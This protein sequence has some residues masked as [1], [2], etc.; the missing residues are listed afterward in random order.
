MIRMENYPFKA[1]TDLSGMSQSFDN[2]RYPHVIGEC[3]TDKFARVDV[4]D[5]GKV[6][7]LAA[8]TRQVGDITYVDVVRPVSGES[9][10][11]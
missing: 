10:A 7:V 5:R 11:Y 3:M 8:L 1:S 6:H 4:D 9:A 2:Q